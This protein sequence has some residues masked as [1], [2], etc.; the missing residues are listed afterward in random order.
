MYYEEMESRLSMLEKHTVKEDT[1]LLQERG[2]EEKP[3][4]IVKRVTL[5]HL[6]R[7]IITPILQLFF[8]AK[9]IVKVKDDYYFVFPKFTLVCSF[10]PKNVIKGIEDADKI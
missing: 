7:H 4:A 5:W 9:E 3:P 2:Q 10:G 8:T 6:L 1:N